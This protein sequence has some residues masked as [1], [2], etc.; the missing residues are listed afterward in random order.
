MCN[1]TLDSIKCKTYLSINLFPPPSHIR[2]AIN[3]LCVCLYVCLLPKFEGVL[4]CLFSIELAYENPKYKSLN[5]K[6]KSKKLKVKTQ[7]AKDNKGK[8]LSEDKT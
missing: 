4:G 3:Y 6:D 1:R 2:N 5:T 7:K 8:N